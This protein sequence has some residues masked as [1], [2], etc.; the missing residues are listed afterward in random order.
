MSYIL[1]KHLA[2][3]A[4]YGSHRNISA[5]EYFVIHY[6]SNDGDTDENNGKYFANNVVKASAHYFIDDDSITQSVPDD[7]VAYAVGGKKYANCGATGG[8]K[9]YGKCTNANSLS[10]EICDDVKDGVV[11]PSDA[12]FDNVVAFVKLKMKEYN[13]PIERV[14]RHFDVT[15]KSCPAY[16]CGS[17]EKD[18]KWEAFKKRL[19]G[20]STT[21]SATT[22]TKVQPLKV[23][24]NIKSVQTYLKQYYGKEIKAVLGKELAV[25][26]LAGP[27]TRKALAVAFQVELN[28]LGAGTQMPE[29]G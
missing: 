11:S 26:G 27:N 22:T 14:I 29:S 17:K 25:D 8:G 5:I 10:F 1:K 19:T 9:F 23:T 20:T 18:A 7:Y 4:N 13:I 28:K 24:G 15:G 3:K 21:T 12:T 2:N 6:T 16:F